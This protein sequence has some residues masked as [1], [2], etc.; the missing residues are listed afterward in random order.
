MQILGYETMHIKSFAVFDSSGN[1]DE[2]A[3]KFKTHL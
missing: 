3:N 1:V 2:P